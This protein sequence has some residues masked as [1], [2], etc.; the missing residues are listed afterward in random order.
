MRQSR[1]E[2][3]FNPVRSFGFASRGMLA[4]QQLFSYPLRAPLLGHVA[5][6]LG[7]ADD[8]AFGIDDWRNG[9]RDVAPSAV[10]GEAYG[11]IVVNGFAA[12]QPGE[13]VRFF[14]RSFR[15]NQQ[16][17]RLSDHFG[18]RVTVEFLGAGVPTGDDSVQIFAN[19]CI[20]TRFDDRGQPFGNN[21]GLFPFSDVQSESGQPVWNS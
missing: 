7:A 16:G 4:Q 8:F 3:I 5:S 13:N 10:L 11:F 12:A 9:E 21:L 1:Q 19:D 14:V 6:D 20:V 15:R 2:L 17:D 18:G